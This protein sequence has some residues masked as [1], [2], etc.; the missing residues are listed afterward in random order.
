MINTCKICNSYSNSFLT[1]DLYNS[2]FLICFNCNKEC[3]LCKLDY[4]KIKE[5]CNNCVIIYI[6][7][8]NNNITNKLPVEIINIIFNYTKSAYLLPYLD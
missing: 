4:F 6:K 8:T 1:K 5:I 2:S 7:N 3:F